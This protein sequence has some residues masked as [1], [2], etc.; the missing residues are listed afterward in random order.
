MNDDAACRPVFRLACL[1]LGRSLLAPLMWLCPLQGTTHLARR[2]VIPMYM[3]NAIQQ[4]SWSF[5]PLRRLSLSESTPPRFAWPGTFR[6]Q[7][8]PPSRRITPRSDV[9][10]YFRLVTSMGFCSSGVFPHCQVPLT[11]RLN[12]ITLLA[13][14]LS[15]PYLGTTGFEALGTGA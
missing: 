5:L 6:P 8:F 4:L 13:F 11:H 7:G 9:Q 15:A 14:L 12:G 1:P 10:P 2:F 3:R